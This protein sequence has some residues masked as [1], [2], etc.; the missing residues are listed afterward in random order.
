MI[1]KLTVSCHLLHQGLSLHRL[2]HQW[3]PIASLPSASYGSTAWFTL[4]DLRTTHSGEA[5]RDPAEPTTE[6]S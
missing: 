3:P 2:L 4:A 6:R 5:R 1:E